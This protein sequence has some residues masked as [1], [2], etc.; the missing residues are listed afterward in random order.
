MPIISYQET[1]INYVKET[2]F[3]GIWLDK[4][5]N[6]R[7]HTEILAVRLSK[8]CFALRSIEKV[9]GINSMRTLY[10]SCFNSLITYGVIFWGNSTGS[11]LIFKLQKIIMEA[12]KRT[13][14][15]PL[16]KKLQILPLPCIYIL[17]TLV[18]IQTHL[19]SFKTNNTY[20]HITIGS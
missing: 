1:P 12:N 7:K 19:T 2:K 11:Q 20:T 10:Y 17:E 9:T 14:C 4:H 3:L 6:W 13:S 18:F 16:F 15:R 5:L 8:I